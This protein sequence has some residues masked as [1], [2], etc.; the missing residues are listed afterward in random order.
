MDRTVE[1][2]LSGG[3]WVER[4]HFAGFVRWLVAFDDEVLSGLWH[5]NWIFE[6]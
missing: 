2:G 5:T 4:W 3:T 1:R 6:I